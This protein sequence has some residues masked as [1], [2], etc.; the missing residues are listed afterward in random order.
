MTVYKSKFGLIK[1]GNLILYKIDSEPIA[2]VSIVDI[3]MSKNNL[4]LN[5]FFNLFKRNEYDFIIM[6]DSEKQIK[7]SFGKKNLVV[8]QNLKKESCT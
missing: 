5:F 4:C 6:L 3:K 2:L 1:E 8:L 7:F